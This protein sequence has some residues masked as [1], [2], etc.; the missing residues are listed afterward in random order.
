[1][2]LVLAGAIKSEVFFFNPVVFARLDSKDKLAVNEPLAALIQQ[3]RIDS[4]AERIAQ[5]VTNTSSPSA[6]RSATVIPW[7]W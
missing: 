2:V 3:Q 1:M 6:F 5:R 7:L 4:V